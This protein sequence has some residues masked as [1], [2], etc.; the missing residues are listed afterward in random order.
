MYR[1]GPSR[2]TFILCCREEPAGGTEEPAGGPPA[3]GASLYNT[4]MTLPAGG[5]AGVA[6][7]KVGDLHSGGWDA[8]AARVGVR[9]GRAEYRQLRLPLGRQAIWARG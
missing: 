5:A 1:R 9:E 4:Q 3:G 7:V 8:A 2:P 6:E